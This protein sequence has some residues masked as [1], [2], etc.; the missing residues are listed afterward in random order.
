MKR[1]TIFDVRIKEPISALSH[2]AGIIFAIVALVLL[3]TYAVLHATTWHVVS[4]AVFGSCAILLFTA[5]TLYH[6]LPLK[7]S[8]EKFFR[9]LDHSSIYLM[10]AG[11]YT[12]TCLI[13]LRGWLGYSL[14]STV[15]AGALVG[16]GLCFS[17]AKAVYRRGISIT[18]Y[19]TLGWLSIFAIYPLA[20][21]LSWQALFWLIFGGILYSIGAFIY[22]LKKPRLFPRVFG[23]HELFHFFVLGGAF[24]HF[25]FMFGFIANANLPL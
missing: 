10:I 14:L 1:L 25:W 7:V 21:S 17:R 19:L 6:W 18:L 24:C 4:F 2:F 12:P 8:Q 20:Q 9:K 15:W 11:S 16:I 3:V 13:M 23:F 5:S 22:L